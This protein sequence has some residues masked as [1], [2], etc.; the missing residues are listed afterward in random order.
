MPVWYKSGIRWWQIHRGDW[1]LCWHPSGI[2]ISQR[3]WELLQTKKC[4][5]IQKFLST[6]DLNT[7]GYFSNSVNTQGIWPAVLLLSKWKNYHWVT[8]WGYSRPD[9]SYQL[10]NDSRTLFGWCCSMGILL[11]QSIQGLQSLLWP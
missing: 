4:K 6:V 7:R 1:I 2:H 11:C 5:V 10:E 3:F 9:C 8:I